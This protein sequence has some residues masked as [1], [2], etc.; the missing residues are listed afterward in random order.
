MGAK[1]QSI[2]HTDSTHEVKQNKH[3]QRLNLL[4]HVKHKPKNHRIEGKNR[5]NNLKFFNKNLYDF[6]HKLFYYGAWMAPCFIIDN[7]TH[8][9]RHLPRIIFSG[10]PFEWNEKQKGH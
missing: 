5:G 9:M 2:S 3:K 10:A 1:K 6:G 4:F 7:E 8:K